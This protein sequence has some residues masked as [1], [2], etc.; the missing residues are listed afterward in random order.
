MF[1]T[2][3]QIDAALRELEDAIIFSKKYGKAITSVS[4]NTLETIINVC[5]GS[6]DAHI[7]INNT[8][9]KAGYK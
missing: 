5:I 3:E 9:K 4:T 6:L 8:L 7:K 1:E 2:M